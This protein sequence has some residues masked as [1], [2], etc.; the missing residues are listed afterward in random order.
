MWALGVVMFMLLTG[1]SLWS[2]KNNEQMKQ[3]I[4][5]FDSNVDFDV[6]DFENITEEGKQLVISLLRSDPNER[7]SAEDALRSDW[8]ADYTDNQIRPEQHIIPSD[9]SYDD[10]NDGF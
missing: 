5:T 1:N 4:R 8:F 3:E 6:D 7:I 9:D 2:S 10:F